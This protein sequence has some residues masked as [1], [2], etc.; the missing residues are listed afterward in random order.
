MKNT[1]FFSAIT[2]VIAV[3]LIITGYSII[4]INDYTVD[5]QEKSSYT[6][7]MK[8]SFT[9][10]TNDL[11]NISHDIKNIDIFNIKYYSDVKNN[12]D[13]FINKL[14]HIERK[15]RGLEVTANSLLYECKN[16]SYN[17]NDFDY[18]CQIAS[19]N[20]ESVINAYVS[21]VNKYNETIQNYNDWIIVQENGQNNRLNEYV[22]NFYT[23]YID[24]NNDQEYSGIIK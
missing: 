7:L 23:E 13:N 24:I 11:D 16:T 22:S 17:D 1:R 5:A 3:I 20:Y 10:Y 18:K 12:Y 15:I 14:D 21:L 19:Y 8:T 9:S 2:M 6:S 4:F